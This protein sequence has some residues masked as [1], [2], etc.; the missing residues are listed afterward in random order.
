MSTETKCS[1]G[2]RHTVAAAPSNA[3]WWPNQLN[4]KILICLLAAS[5]VGFCAYIFRGAP[6]ITNK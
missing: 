2:A 3:G 1:G 5:C 4:L 6:F